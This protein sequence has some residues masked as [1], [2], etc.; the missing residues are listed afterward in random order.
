MLQRPDIQGRLGGGLVRVVAGLVL[1]AGV[2]APAT[3]AATRD[4]H[5]PAPVRPATTVPAG[6]V[7]GVASGMVVTSGEASGGWLGPIAP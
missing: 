3:A 4:G 1:V 6:A 7:G 2:V 5:A